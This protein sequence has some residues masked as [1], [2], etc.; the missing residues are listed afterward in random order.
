MQLTL[1]AFRSSRDSHESK[2]HSLIFMLKDVRLFV[3]F[4]V[5]CVYDGASN[6]ADGLLLET[7]RSVTDSL[8]YIELIAL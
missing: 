1:C 3:L 2:S 8:L 5:R 7:F 6:V 4:V